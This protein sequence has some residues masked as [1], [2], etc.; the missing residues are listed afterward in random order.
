MLFKYLKRIFC[1]HNNSM[2]SSWHWT[3]G[4]NSNE[5]LFIEAIVKCAKCG[6]TYFVDITNRDMCDRIMEITSSNER[7]HFIFMHKLDF[8]DKKFEKMGYIKIREDEYG[9][10]YERKNNEFNFIHRLD[11]RR[12]SSGN[13]IIQSYDKNL[14]DKDCIGNVCVGLTYPEIKLCLKKMKKLGFHKKK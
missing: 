9:V 12:K 6:K 1:N 13:H 3:H 2:L 8:I 4:L 11:I 7:G 10:S 14:M 5:P